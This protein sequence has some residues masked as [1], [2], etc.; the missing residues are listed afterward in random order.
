[1]LFQL[2]AVLFASLSAVLLI[3]S[4]QV[5][6]LLARIRRAIRNLFGAQESP[7]NHDGLPAD[8]TVSVPPEE[9]PENH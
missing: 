2:L 9:P 6:M 5:R 3:F 7:S 8:D 1:M 4:R